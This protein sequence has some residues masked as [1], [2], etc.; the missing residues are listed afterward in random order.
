MYTEWKLGFEIDI[1]YRELLVFFNLS[2]ILIIVVI[3]AI[4]H[5]NF[6]V[7]TSDLRNTNPAKYIYR[8]KQRRPP[9]AVQL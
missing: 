4:V 7:S 2:V 9:K 1:V 6:A 5:A 3:L 8:G